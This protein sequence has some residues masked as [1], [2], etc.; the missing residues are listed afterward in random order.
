MLTIRI[1]GARELALANVG[2]SY[3]LTPDHALLHGPCPAPD[4]DKFPPLG[5]RCGDNEGTHCIG[6]N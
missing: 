6:E 5:S 2:K 1:K 4:P 3:T